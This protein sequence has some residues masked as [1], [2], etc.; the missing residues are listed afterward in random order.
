MVA[1]RRPKH[2]SKKSPSMMHP[3]PEAQRTLGLTEIKRLMSEGYLS[4][5]TPTMLSP[6]GPSLVHE[7]REL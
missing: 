6:Q 4:A 5:T 1:C 2:R 3:R 7:Q